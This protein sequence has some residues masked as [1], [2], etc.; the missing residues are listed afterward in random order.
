MT[1][2][3][4]SHRFFQALGTVE[5]NEN[6][7]E[8]TSSSVSVENPPINSVFPFTAEFSSTASEKPNPTP[9]PEATSNGAQLTPKSAELF[10]A[11]K[12]AGWNYYSHLMAAKSKP[13]S[14][15]GVLIILGLATAFRVST[16]RLYDLLKH[17]EELIQFHQMYRK[18][19]EEHIKGGSSPKRAERQ[20]IASFTLTVSSNVEDDLDVSATYF[21]LT[22]VLT[23]REGGRWQE[24]I[25]AVAAPE[26]LLIGQDRGEKYDEEDGDDDEN[27]MPS[28]GSLEKHF[29]EDYKS[30]DIDKIIKSGDDD[31]FA[32]MKELLLIP[33]LQLKETCQRLS[34]LSKLINRLDEVEER[35]ESFELED[36]VPPT[37]KEFAK[38]KEGKDLELA[39]SL[40]LEIQQRVRGVLWKSDSGFESEIE[41]LVSKAVSLVI[42]EGQRRANEGGSEIDGKDTS[43]NDDS[44]ESNFGDQSQDFDVDENFC[45]QFLNNDAFL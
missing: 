31:I 14:P 45:V 3:A 5:P 12:E 2:R 33:D 20:A 41:N 30:M 6:V 35:M 4:Q 13:E 7:Q 25:D 27:K 23:L 10:S 28:V 39:L 19:V 44:S 16:L 15:Q 40:S 9:F 18:I 17:R 42:A 34:G 36:M 26:I 11:L 37:S 22:L 29:H 24:L 38:S 43:I 8:G 21:I 32:K 1:A